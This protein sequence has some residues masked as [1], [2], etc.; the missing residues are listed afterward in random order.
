[1]RHRGFGALWVYNRLMSAR[2]SALT[3]NHL[4]RPASTIF[5]SSRA[6]LHS[7]RTRSQDVWATT[8]RRKGKAIK[9]ASNVQ[10]SG[11]HDDLDGAL[12]RP[13]HRHLKAALRLLEKS[14]ARWQDSRAEA[15]RK[16]DHPS[17]LVVLLTRANHI[18]QHRGRHSTAVVCQATG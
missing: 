12:P 7:N 1:M 11:V 17:A 5:G 13:R 3:L 10:S 2:S 6:P 16:Y 14:F 18:R 15:V 8:V 4:R 9:R